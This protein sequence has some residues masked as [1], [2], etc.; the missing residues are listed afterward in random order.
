[1]AWPPVLG[2]SPFLQ[3]LC[4]A[5]YRLIPGGPR[6]RGT[7][8]VM[9]CSNECKQRKHC[10][11]VAFISE[12][13][14]LT[15]SFPTCVLLAMM[16]S[17]HKQAGTISGPDWG[18]HRRGLDFFL[19]VWSSLI[20]SGVCSHSHSPSAFIR[21][22]DG[23]WAGG[24]RCTYQCPANGAPGRAFSSPSVDRAPISWPL[25]IFL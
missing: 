9:S 5:S 17:R 25:L 13:K 10:D 18:T 12:A 22:E 23:G 20:L 15:H 2:G 14:M 21:A 4:T 3:G 16:L 24:Q 7:G 19:P 6:E 8:P 11:Q 1:M